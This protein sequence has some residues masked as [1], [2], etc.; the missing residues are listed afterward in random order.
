MKLILLMTA[1]LQVYSCIPNKKDEKP[2]ARDPGIRVV[3]EY[4]P[5]GR[6]K[7]EIEALGKLRH[8]VTKEY[9]SDGTLESLI[10]YKENRKHG[11]AVN[12]YSDGKTIKT[13]IEYENGYKQGE[14][15]WYYPAQF[16]L[17]VFI[18]SKCRQ[19]E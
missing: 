6:L 2:P 12:Y 11:P 18:M 3:K 10:H 9:R 8:G 5:N 17:L 1:L 4:H 16:P 19:K 7:S 14:A 13:E 15:K